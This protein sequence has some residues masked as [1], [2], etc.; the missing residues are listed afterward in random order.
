MTEEEIQYARYRTR[1]KVMKRI[2]NEIISYRHSLLPLSRP[3]SPAAGISGVQQTLKLEI[4]NRT[5]STQFI[6]FPP[7]F[8]RPAFLSSALRWGN[9]IL[10][11]APKFIC[12]S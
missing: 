11:R 12:A 2:R 1:A 6:G 5:P 7:C 3:R 8:G 10:G 9:P 4:L